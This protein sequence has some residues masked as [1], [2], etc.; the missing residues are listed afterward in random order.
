MQ[1]ALSKKSTSGN[2]L[3]SENERSRGR[4]EIQLT[5]QK[6]AITLSWI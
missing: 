5:K 4:G 6:T 3:K 1:S 2:T